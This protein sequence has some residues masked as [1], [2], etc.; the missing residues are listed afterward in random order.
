MIMSKREELTLIVIA[1]TLVILPIAV[2]FLLVTILL[3][4]WPLQLPEGWRDLINYYT[5][6]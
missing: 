5:P 3:F 1:W 6:F 4:D 2:T